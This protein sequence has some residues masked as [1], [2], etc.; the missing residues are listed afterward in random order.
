MIQFTRIASSMSPT[1]RLNLLSRLSSAVLISYI[2]LATPSYGSERIRWT[3]DPERG[4]VS[5]TLSG[6]RRGQEDVGCDTA[7]STTRLAPIVP[8]DRANLFTTLAN[9]TLAWNVSTVAPVSM[10]FH[11]SDPAV[12]TPLYTQTV[13]VEKSTTISVTVPNEH[14]LELGKKYRWTVFVS[15]PDH[16]QTEISARSF[17][18][19]VD[20]ESLSIDSLSSLE[21]ARIYARQG[22]WYDAVAALLAAGSQGENDAEIMVKTLLEQGN[23]PADI[24]LAAVVQL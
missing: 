13:S 23:N 17:I 1:G 22:I 24:N 19:R 18:E 20:R 3:P 14:S 4:S 16:I 10:T 9:P 8:G 21:Q 7:D 5:S 15:C 2:G 6:G 11:F 12:A